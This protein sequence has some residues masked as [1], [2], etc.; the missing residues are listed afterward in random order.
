[1]RSVFK[2]LLL[3]GASMLTIVL[4]AC[5]PFGNGF[6]GFGSGADAPRNSEGEVTSSATAATTKINVGDCIRNP[7][8]DTG[9][10]TPAPS[11]GSI[12]IEK[13]LQLPCAQPSDYE[14]YAGTGI[15]AAD[16][17]GVQ[18][19]IASAEAFCKPAFEDFVGRTFE[20]SELQLSYIY[21]TEDSWNSGDR[22]T[23]CL[24]AAKDGAQ[25]TG[26]LKG[27]NR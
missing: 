26:S 4:S 19:L 17:P 14:V 23:L 2:P 25:S 10:E 24:V 6:G 7:G 9:A 18:S 15:E 21:P 20:N 22:R 11:S 27:A 5:A 1:M 8:V 13:V 16:Y 3:I 12:E